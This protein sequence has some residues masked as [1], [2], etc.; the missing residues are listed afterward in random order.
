MMMQLVNDI[1]VVIFSSKYLKNKMLQNSITARIPSI[2]SSI[3]VYFA[4][5]ERFALNFEYDVTK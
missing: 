1:I 3:T 2:L 4:Q 5:E